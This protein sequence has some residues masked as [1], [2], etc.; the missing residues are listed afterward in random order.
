M[1]VCLVFWL[2]VSVISSLHDLPHPRV[3]FLS[4]GWHRC[5]HLTP[6]EHFLLVVML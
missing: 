3:V 2:L 6:S 1:F 5:P 4:A